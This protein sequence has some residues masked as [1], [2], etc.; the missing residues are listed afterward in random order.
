[1]QHKDIDHRSSN[2]S[3]EDAKEGDTRK[4]NK[5]RKKGGKTEAKNYDD[6][7]SDVR[8]VNAQSQAFML[9]EDGPLKI[10]ESHQIGFEDEASCLQTNKEDNSDE[11]VKEKKIKTGNKEYETDEKAEGEKDDGRLGLTSQ[12]KDDEN[13][14]GYK[15]KEWNKE[16]QDDKEIKTKTNATRQINTG[17]RYMTLSSGGPKVQEQEHIRDARLNRSE[18]ALRLSRSFIGSGVNSEKSFVIG[19]AEKRNQTKES[20]IREM[21]DDNEDIEKSNIINSLTMNSLP[22]QNIS[23]HANPLNA[24]RDD[25]R[26]DQLVVPSL[27]MS[28]TEFSN[29]TGRNEVHDPMKPEEKKNDPP[30]EGLIAHNEES[31]ELKITILP[32]D[33]NDDG[34]ISAEDLLCFA[35]QTACGMVSGQDRQ[36]KKQNR[37]NISTSYKIYRLK[38]TCTYVQKLLPFLFPCPPPAPPPFKTF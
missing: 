20:E 14:I 3:H 25:E 22:Q 28:L 26:V 31:T 5:E 10:K 27:E 2:S 21:E 34:V 29:I 15:R 19:G 4:E 7:A 38:S 16:V 33:D 9:K 6:K 13:K 23:C 11:C 18:N 24:N 30:E 1:M 17:A 12:S 8:Y 37:R 35:W 36:L 32:D